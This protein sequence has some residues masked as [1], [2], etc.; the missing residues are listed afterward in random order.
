MVVV[1]KKFFVVL[2]G[3]VL[4]IMLFAACELEDTSIKTE[5]SRP[6]RG[7]IQ[8]GMIVSSSEEELHPTALYKAAQDD[9]KITVKTGVTDENCYSVTLELANLGC[10]V[11]FAA[12]DGIEDYIVQ[13][14]TE[15]TDVQ[16]CMANG[17]QSEQI[18]LPNLHSY[19]VKETEA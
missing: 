10:D 9:D 6:K 18:K 13:A 1:V 2:L 3:A 16:F 5:E 4:M 12:G 11:I 15:E 7:A 17:I 19:A 8:I 14:A